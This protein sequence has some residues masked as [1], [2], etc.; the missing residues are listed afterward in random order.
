MDLDNILDKIIAHRPESEDLPSR[1][2]ET[3]V[4]APPLG[5][6][7]APSLGMIASPIGEP[8]SKIRVML[9]DGSVHHINLKTVPVIQRSVDDIYTLM[10]PDTSNGILL[11]PL[12]AFSESSD[13]VSYQIIKDYLDSDN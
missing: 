1:K 8:K 10:W 9:Y 7:N 12:Y 3:V 11:K 2:L 5:V 13:P 4:R 6:G